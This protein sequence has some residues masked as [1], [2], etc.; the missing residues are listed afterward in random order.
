MINFDFKTTVTNVIKEED[1]LQYKN[2]KNEIME[3][4]QKCDMIGWDK[5]VS[6]KNVDFIKQMMKEVKKNSSLL[7]VIGIGG[8]FLGSKALYDMFEHYFSNQ[9]KVIYC[10]YSLSSNYLSDLLKLLKDKDFTVNVISKSGN[11]MEIKLAYNLIKE[12]MQEKYSEE[13][14]KERIIITTGTSGYLYEEAKKSNYRTL[15]IP[16][17]IGGRYSMMTDAHLFPLSFNL[18]IDKFIKGYNDGNTIKKEAYEYA[19]TRKSLFDKNKLIENYV[20]FEPKYE[21]FIEWLKQLFG[22]SE[23]KNGKGIFPVSTI[24]TRDLHS[25]G[26]FIQEGNKILFE[27]FIIVRNNSEIKIDNTNLNNINNA[28]V[29]AVRNAHYKGDVAV[30]FIEIDEL[31]EYNMGL[32]IKF[33]FYSAAFSSLLFEV[34]PFDQPGVEVYKSEIK[35]SLENL[36][37]EG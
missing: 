22:E 35:Q 29:D 14:I 11:T 5:N 1:L 10:G 26:Q 19:I 18:D 17:D 9:F 20:S 2:K 3:A 32:L 36:K 25:L 21:M 23:G 28:V 4:F 13:E 34:N 37:E 33:F 8:S 16:D 6:T 24:F 7:L 12:F 15:S 30:N 27:T 31:N